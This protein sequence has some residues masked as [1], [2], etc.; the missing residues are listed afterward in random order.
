[1]L[2]DGHILTCLRFDNDS[3]VFS[4]DGHYPILAG[5]DPET[6]DPLYVAVVHQEVDSPWYFTTAKDG[7][8]SV[9]YTN[10]VGERLESSNFFVLALRHDPID[11]P[12]QDIRH[13]AGAKDPTGPVY[14]VEFWPTK[15]VH[16]FDDE[17][18]RDD[19]LLKSFLEDLRERKMTESILDGFD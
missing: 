12:P 17:R 2:L 11:L 16:Y 9:E 8:S 15:D 19:R 5:V 6:A 3:P 7:A 10:E 18:L 13:R 4:C 1:M 14:W